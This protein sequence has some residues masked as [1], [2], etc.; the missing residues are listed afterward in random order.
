MKTVIGI[1]VVLILVAGGWYLWNNREEA[2]MGPVE[3]IEQNDASFTY[4]SEN[5]T[6]VD[7][8]KDQVPHDTFV[9][10]YTIFDA[11]EYEALQNST[12]PREGPPAISILVFSNPNNY[13]ARQ[14]VIE[15]SFIA[16]YQE[17]VAIED[18]TVN[19]YAGVEYIADGLYASKVTVIA[20]PEYVYFVSAGF[21]SADDALLVEYEHILSSITIAEGLPLGPSEQEVDP[22]AL[23][24]GKEL[25]KPVSPDGPIPIEG[26]DANLLLGRYDGLAAAD[27]NGV[28][29]LQGIY[30]YEN[31]E[32]TF[33]LTEEFEH[34][35]ARTIAPA[36]YEVLLENVASRLNV[37]IQSEAD[38]DALIENL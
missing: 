13:D 7:I 18:V 36:G 5:Y 11:K 38:V 37:V 25:T 23:Y 8:E 12:E 22:F 21:I 1:V 33:T 6:L 27:F 4:H 32:L 15:E 24:F 16:N 26:Y 17:G 29:A 30:T 31:G 2:A 28:A 34:S 10:G 35:A 20:G 19:G 14:W 9:Y 3:R